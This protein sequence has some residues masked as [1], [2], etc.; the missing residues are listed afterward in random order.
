VIFESA[1]SLR[2][3]VET[4]RVDLRNRFVISF[5]GCDC[6]SDFLGDSVRTVRDANYMIRLTAK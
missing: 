6:G 3:M 2:M 4:D 5:I 1:L